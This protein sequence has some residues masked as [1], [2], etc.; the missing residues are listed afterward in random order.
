MLGETTYLHKA[1]LAVNSAYF[2]RLFEEVIP[3]S[4]PHLSSD[5]KLITLQGYDHDE[6]ENDP[7]DDDEAMEKMFLHMYGF[8]VFPSA[9]S[10]DFEENIRECLG[11]LAVASKYE[12]PHIGEKAKKCIA[13]QLAGMKG[14][15]ASTL[16]CSEMLK[17][18]YKAPKG[19]GTLRRLAAGAFRR[20]LLSLVEEDHFQ[21]LLDRFPRMAMDLLKRPAAVVDQ[22]EHVAKKRKVMRE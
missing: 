3:I 5:H 11:L 19:D 8:D 18:I 6:I 16:E 21:E 7:D 22:E 14:G 15:E 2:Q 1:I 4:S 17:L 10:C 12:A 20:D 9:D 13:E